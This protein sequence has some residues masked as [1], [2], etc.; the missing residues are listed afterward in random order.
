MLARGL[1]EKAEIRVGV[2]YVAAA[3]LAGV[4][5]KLMVSPGGALVLAPWPARIGA[6][7]VAL[8]MFY[9]A[10]RSVVAGVLSGVGAVVAA[11]WWA[12]A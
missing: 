6:L 4:V 2:R 7:A 8:V 3:I 11:S 5:A 1:D 9:A 12:G 10:R